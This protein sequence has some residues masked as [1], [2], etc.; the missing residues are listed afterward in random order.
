MLLA[1]RALRKTYQTLSWKNCSPAPWVAPIPSPLRR[2]IRGLRRWDSTT[3]GID[4]LRGLL[5]GELPDFNGQ[6]TE[7]EYSIF[8]VRGL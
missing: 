6:L 1:L 3:W 2:L 5:H 8:G 4:S 7:R